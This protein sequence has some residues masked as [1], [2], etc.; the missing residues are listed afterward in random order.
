MP[1][2]A[3]LSDHRGLGRDGPQH[4]RVLGGVE[5]ADRL[6]V[7]YDDIPVVRLGDAVSERLERLDGLLDPLLE[8]GARIDLSPRYPRQRHGEA[9]SMLW[10]LE[11]GSMSA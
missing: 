2:A 9:R 8:H 7:A 1:R 4:R 10:I 3:P 11:I 5:P 6:H